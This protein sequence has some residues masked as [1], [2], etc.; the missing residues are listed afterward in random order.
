[1]QILSYSTRIPMCP[2]PSTQ[3]PVADSLG[4]ASRRHGLDR[5]D[6]QPTPKLPHEPLGNLA[7]S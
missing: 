2:V 4:A 5:G 6:H 7:Q 3:G 1:M